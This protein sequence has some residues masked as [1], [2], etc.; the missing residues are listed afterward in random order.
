MSQVQVKD[1]RSG[2]KVIGQCSVTLFDTLDEAEDALKE[3]GILAYVNR[4]VTIETMD[5][6]RRELTGSGSS[7]IRD[8]MKKVKENPE[9]FAQLKALLG[10]S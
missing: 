4:G 8:M 5:A 1:V 3:E 7:G 2:G 10:E 6:K 9:L